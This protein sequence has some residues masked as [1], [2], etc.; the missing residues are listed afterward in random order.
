MGHQDEAV[1]V[2]RLEPGEHPK[3]YKLVR[4][5]QALDI[6]KSKYD[7]AIQDAPLYEAVCFK[8][9]RLVS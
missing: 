5:V 2:D 6:S 9:R 1:E 8:S 3:V 4:L 7:L